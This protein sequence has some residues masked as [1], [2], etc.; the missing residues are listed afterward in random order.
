MPNQDEVTEQL[1]TELLITLLGITHD[2]NQAGFILSDGRL[3][4]LQRKNVVK[5][6]NHLDVIKLLPRFHDQKEPISDTQMI[7]IM[8]KEHLVRFCINGTIHTAIQPNSI[9]MRK[10]YNMLA[11]RSSPFEVIVSNAAGMT[12]AQH[13]VSGPSM[14]SLVNIFKIYKDQAQFIKSDEFF[15][16][17][18]DSHYQLVFRPSMTVVGRM[19]KISKLLK[20][21]DKFKDTNKIFYQLITEFKQDP[22]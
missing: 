1:D 6:M 13:R 11:Y 17:Q 10:I 16:Q 12:L 15:V 18:T 19:N 9:Q 7:E 14:G 5:R 22:H 3:L 20:M 8:A 21:E 2:T 4:H